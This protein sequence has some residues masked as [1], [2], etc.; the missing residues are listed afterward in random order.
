MGK[1]IALEIYL[2]KVPITGKKLVCVQILVGMSSVLLYLCSKGLYCIFYNNLTGVFS[3]LDLY[4]NQLA[5][6]ISTNIW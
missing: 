1:T 6:T 5:Q 4:E 2:E 3:C